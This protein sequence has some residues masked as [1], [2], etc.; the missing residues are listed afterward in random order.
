MAIFFYQGDGLRKSVLWKDDEGKIT[1]I[2]TYKVWSKR[3]YFTRK[4]NKIITNKY[5]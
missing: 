1:H 5:M 2:H 4:V 3:K